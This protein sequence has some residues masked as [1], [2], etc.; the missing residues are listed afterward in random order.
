MRLI[1]R[2]DMGPARGKKALVRP[3]ERLVVGR[4]ERAGLVVPHDENLS[5]LHFEL[6][7]DGERCLARDLGSAKGTE[8]NGEP[9]AEGELEHGD[10]L[11]AGDTFFNISVEGRV[12]PRYPDEDERRAPPVPAG[13]KAE[14]LAALKAEKAPLYTVLDAARESWI[15]HLVAAV[16][17]DAQSLYEGE[18]GE[19]LFDVAPYLVSLPKD[20]WA[21]ARLVDEGWGRGW[22]IFLTS[23]RPFKEVRRHLRRLLIVQEKETETP[24]YFRFYDPAVLPAALTVCNPRQ[25]QQMFGD[26]E[27]YLVEDDDARVLRLSP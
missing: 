26:V 22:G 19:E 13:R 9:R 27:A 12:P 15:L 7:W 8:L 6:A 4:L 10:W 20:G 18:E 21:L 24:L 11:R 3:G 23:K 14:A 2:I 5:G 1:V 25:K 16:A 17:E